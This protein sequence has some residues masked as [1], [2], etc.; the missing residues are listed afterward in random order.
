MNTK[1]YLLVIK[2]N[3]HLK[4]PAASTAML[5]LTLSGNCAREASFVGQPPSGVLFYFNNLVVF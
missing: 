5:I 1:K 3:L 4:L 2:L